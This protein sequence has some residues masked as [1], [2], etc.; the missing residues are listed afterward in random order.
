MFK[1]HLNHSPLQLQCFLQVHK[2][3]FFSFHKIF[4]LRTWFFPRN[5]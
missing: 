1:S 5:I 2:P 4:V 3:P